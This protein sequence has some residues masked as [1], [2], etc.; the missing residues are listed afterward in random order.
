MDNAEVERLQEHWKRT[1]ELRNDQITTFDKS[2][3]W[4]SGGALALTIANVDKLEGSG[5]GIGILL[6]ASWLSFA[7]SVCANIISYWTSTQDAECE[8]ERIRESVEEGKPYEVGNWYRKAT[9]IFNFT[10]L[11]LFLIGVFL[12]IGHAYLNLGN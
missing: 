9:Y 4:A 2:V 6:L 7:V 12:L 3:L 8:L 5:D 11:G 10:A 1:L